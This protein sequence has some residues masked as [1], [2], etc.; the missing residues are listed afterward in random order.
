MEAGR[1]SRPPRFPALRV[2]HR[3]HEEDVPAMTEH[4][5]GDGLKLRWA[6][7]DDVERQV[8]LTATSFLQHPGGPPTIEPGPW[9]RDLASGRH[10]QSSVDRLAIVEDMRRGI[11]V[12]CTWLIAMPVTYDGIPL[13]AG[14]PEHV[15]THPD[16]RRRG[17]AGELFRWI[18][19]RS[20][21]E[22]HLAQMI[23]GIP[24]FY[25]QFGYEY[26]IE[27]GGGVMV[28]RTAMRRRPAP[29]GYT[30]RPATP[31][32]LPDTLA[33]FSS[34]HRDCLVRN[35]FSLDYWMWMHDGIDHEYGFGWQSL[36]VV[37][38]QDRTSG[39]ILME[40]RRRGRTVTVQGIAATEHAS[41][42]EILPSALHAIDDVASQLPVLPLVRMADYENIRFS[43]GSGHPVRRLLATA[44]GA[45]DIAEDAW[46]VRVADLP[47][48]LRA[49][50]PAIERRLAASPLRGFSGILA[51][52]HYRTGLAITFER[53]VLAG[54]TDGRPGPH[55]PAAAAGLPPG[56]ILQVIFG[57]R[58][59]PELRHILPD[60][61]ATPDAELLLDIIFPMRPSHLL[62]V[63]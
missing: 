44:Y 1:S 31:D 63:N 49:I 16:Y 4:D 22:G 34:S 35:D 8:A 57:R 51:I 29:A 3:H 28:E 42:H 2:P 58:T 62:P 24:H 14:R 20:Q 10:P 46:L 59:L 60:V 38:E 12:S 40:T 36:V 39:A 54:V 37:D 61:W 9:A 15:A 11:V 47:R 26:A 17:L 55:L 53:G 56:V 23:T 21:D 30:V 6:G 19:Q 32:E 43:V 50:S 25:R 7:P 45:R 18:H 33:L 48:L 41:L 13:S 27:L 5:L 52:D